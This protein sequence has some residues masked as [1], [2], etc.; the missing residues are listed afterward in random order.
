MRDGTG[1]PDASRRAR[2]PVVVMECFE[3][4]PCDPCHDACPRGAIQPFEDICRLPA[5]DFERCNGCGTCISSCPGLAIFVV[6]ETLPDG[7]ARVG[8][9]YEFLPLPRAGDV[10]SG[11]GRDGEPLCRARVAR[12]DSGSSRDRTHVV[13]V[14]VPRELSMEVRHI[15]VA[16][17]AAGARERPAGAASSHAPAGAASSEA[18]AR[19]DETIVVCR[20]EDVTLDEIRRLIAAGY[21]TLDEIKRITRCTMGPC[22]G[23]TCRQL[24]LEEIARATGRDVASL[25]PTRFRPPTKPVQLRGIAEGDAHG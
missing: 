6:D 13:W 9:P 16:G 25:A 23:R 1:I 7:L 11:L 20:C 5:V 4:I 21:T 3:E 22:Q 2:G 19:A 8:L 17:D 24:V 18:H 12:V 14:D 10:V 15:R